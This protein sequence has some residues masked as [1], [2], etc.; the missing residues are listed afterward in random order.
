MGPS[1]LNR[2][3]RKLDEPKRRFDCL[4]SYSHSHLFALTLTLVLALTFTLTLVMHR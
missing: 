2:F 1:P 3:V 4:Y